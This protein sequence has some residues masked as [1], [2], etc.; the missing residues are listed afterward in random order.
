MA[1]T[2][3][4]FGIPKLNN[5]NYQ[6]WKFKVEK[7]LKREGTWKAISGTR[8][9]N[10]DDAAD[11]WDLRDDKALGTICLLIEDTQISL[12]RDKTT[13]KEA[14]DALKQYH[15]K[16]SGLNKF[17]L[18]VELLKLSYQDGD[19]MEKHIAKIQELIDNLLALGN[20]SAVEFGPWI[21]LRSMPASYHILISV[22]ASRPEEELS[23][24]V[25][26]ATLISEFKRRKSLSPNEEYDTAMRVNANN[27][28]IMCYFCQ[29]YGHLKSDCPKYIAW[30]RKQRRRKEQGKAAIENNTSSD[31]D[32]SFSDNT[33]HQAYIATSNSSQ[34]NW[35]LDT[36]ASNHMTNDISFFETIDTSYTSTVN[37][38][39]GQACKVY[40]AGEGRIECLTKK[41]KTTVL[42][43][44]NVLYVPNFDCSLISIGTLDKLGFRLEIINNQM[45]IYTKNN[46][47]MAIGDALGQIYK[48]R[49]PE[50]AFAVM[51]QHPEDCIHQWHTRF[52]HRDPKIIRCLINNNSVTDMKI[53]DCPIKQVCEC[54]I[55]GKISRKP[56]PKESK[57]HAEKP[58]DLIHS[59]LC[60]P[61]PT[62]TPGGR[63]YIMTLI[64][65]YSRY[66]YVFLLRQ[67]LQ[68]TEVIKNFIE[69]CITQFSC[70]PK[71]FDQ[72]WEASTQIMI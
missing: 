6:I 19:D 50:Y 26:K 53:N 7:L 43:L 24:D 47:E 38:A 71:L 37:V 4:A 40:G 28:Q 69:F 51:P 21:V 14:W 65:D 8:P 35:Y 23:I 36:A 66:T 29:Q 70:K 58:F 59:D 46:N 39:N 32:D 49:R 11:S 15:E 63:R 16:A 10:N 3:A 52:G 64:D 41:G 17:T 34:T 56:F 20:R 25:V 22:L 62:Q 27:G 67:K 44:T 54:C 9:T 55:K 42:K 60:R 45:V 2:N 61:M 5:S 68:A 30:K 48:L 13:A 72:I 18:I 12:I 33:P 31:D 1:D 57:S